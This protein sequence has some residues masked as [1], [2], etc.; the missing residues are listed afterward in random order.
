MKLAAIRIPC[1]NLKDAETF[2]VDKLGLNIAF[3]S[4]TDGYIGLQ[5]QN[6]QVILELEEKSEFECGNYLV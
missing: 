3:G 4:L 1:R 6:T 5:L 2:Y